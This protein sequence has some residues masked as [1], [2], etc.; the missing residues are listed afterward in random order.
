MITN[1]IRPLIKLRLVIVQIILIVP[2]VLEHY[3]SNKRVFRT[4]SGWKYIHLYRVST[5]TN[6]RPESWVSR[7][8]GFERVR[9]WEVPGSQ[10]QNNIW[11]AQYLGTHGKK[12]SVN[13]RFFPQDFW[14]FET[15]NFKSTC[16]KN[17][18][19]EFSS[20]YSHFFIMK[21][22][23]LYNSEDLQHNRCWI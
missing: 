11:R 14:D 22:F 1:W 3:S 23:L 12:Y 6:I 13:F 20:F 15:V 19:Q 5:S 17:V 4:S 16:S 7:A 18:W 9:T 2:R 8:R 21:N 10:A